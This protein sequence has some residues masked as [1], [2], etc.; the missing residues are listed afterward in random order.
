MNPVVT[1]KLKTSIV[2]RLEQKTIELKTNTDAI[3]NKAL[4]DYFYFEKLNS[5]RKEVKGQAKKLGFENEENIFNN[6]S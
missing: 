1:I 5:L 2:N 3:I 4:E 6:I